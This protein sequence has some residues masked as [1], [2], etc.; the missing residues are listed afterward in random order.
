[1]NFDALKLPPS[2]A[3]ALILDDEIEICKSIERDLRNVI[4]VDSFQDP[5]LALASLRTKEYSVILSDLQ[6]PK[7]SGLQ[8]LAEAA[9]IR[10]HTQRI[11]IT[12]F[13]DLASV[14]DSVNHAK[15]HSLVNKPWE[16]GDLRSTVDA[17]QRNYDLLRENGELRRL[18]LTDALTGVS[19]LRYF[20]ER[21]QAES[22]RAKRFKRPLTLIMA[23]IDDFKK[24]NDEHGHQHGDQVLR[25]VAQC[26][27]GARRSM[28][29]VARYGGEEFV[30]LLPEASRSQGVEI[31]KR[32]LENVLQKTGIAL[33]MGVSSFPEDGDTSEKLIHSADMAMLNAKKN[34]KRQ[35]REA[36]L[37]R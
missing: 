19:N 35:V 13:A 15:I 12:A 27:E 36:S 9:K 18:A 1:M 8:F 10:P 31:A 16:G 2:P 34:G 17:L 5:Q 24:Y 25:K 20:N 14:S 4:A 29:T 11:L 28:D 30:I 33:S 32:H 37:E 21:L 26:L 6:M 23:D 3:C 7:M 22:S